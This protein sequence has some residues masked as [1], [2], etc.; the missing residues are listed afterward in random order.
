[1][2]SDDYNEF[3]EEI[4]GSGAH[5]FDLNKLDSCDDYDTLD[6]YNYDEYVADPWCRHRY[7]SSFGGDELF[8]SDYCDY[9][10]GRLD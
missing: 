9:V 8:L 6:E 4:E 2:S 5:G 1:M 10:V 7:E 3:I